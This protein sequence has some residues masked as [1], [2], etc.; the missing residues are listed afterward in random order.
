[1]LSKKLKTLTLYQLSA[2][3]L[4]N[5]IMGGVLL[6]NLILGIILKQSDDVAGSIDFPVMITALIWGYIFFAEVFNFAIINGV[7]R[8]SYFISTCIFSL[9]LA[10][11]TAVI[12]TLFSVLAREFASMATE[13]F[14][15]VYPDATIL[16]IFIWF[17]GALFFL[18]ILGWF[19]GILMHSLSKKAKYILIGVFVAIAPIV[20]LLN[21]YIGGIID[22]LKKIVLLFFGVFGDTINSYVSALMLM[23]LSVLFM[24]AAWLFLRKIEL[25]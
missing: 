4:L 6:L 12:A 25:K 1:M 13:V 9:G 18:I 16:E 10:A 11:G 23:A 15:S 5:L 20:M 8:K 2:V 7:S 24:G 19:L 3:G 22:Y 14:F 17:W 21:H